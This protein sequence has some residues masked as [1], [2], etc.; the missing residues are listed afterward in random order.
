MPAIMSHNGEGVQ[1]EMKEG[2]I[3]MKGR[4]W[5]GVKVSD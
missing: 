4:D 1:E 2:R 5:F 3:G